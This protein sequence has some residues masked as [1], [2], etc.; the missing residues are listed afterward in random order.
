VGRDSGLRLA[1]IA[2]L[3]YGQLGLS[4]A[5]V[6]SVPADVDHALLVAADGATLAAPAPVS[7]SGSRHDAGLCPICLASR[8]AR[9]GIELATAT[10]VRWDARPVVATPREPALALPCA[11]AL[12]SAAPRA[13][14]ARALA[15]A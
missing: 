6:A 14:P 10:G 9:S 2:A 13:P 11:P 12:D 4:A 3:L 15:F 1:L 5:H 8:Q 7:H